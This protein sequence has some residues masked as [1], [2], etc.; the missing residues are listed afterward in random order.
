MSISKLFS[1]DYSASVIAFHAMQEGPEKRIREKE[2]VELTEKLIYAV[3]IRKGYIEGELASE[4]YLKERKNAARLLDAYRISRLSYEEYLAQV[5]RVRVRNFLIRYNTEKSDL[6]RL[7]YA[8]TKVNRDE[9]EISDIAETY[10]EDSRNPVYRVEEEKDRSLSE[11]CLEIIGMRNRGSLLHT[12]KQRTGM[13]VLLLTLPHGKGSGYVPYLSS[14]LGVPEN[15]MFSFF[16]MKEEEERNK[17]EK[18][19]QHHEVIGKHYKGILRLTSAFESASTYEERLEISEHSR[20]LEGMLEKRME[21]LKKDSRGFSQQQI[22]KLMGR[23]R[24]YIGQAL[25]ETRMI[26]ENLC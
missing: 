11:I 13:L 24:S 5:L 19:L 1:E 4:F 9:Y 20:R 25:R 7:E 16:R 15:M 12:V 14:M 17:D 2:L 18:R 23:S 21:A 22:A 8:I 3:P 6:A 10:E 26:L